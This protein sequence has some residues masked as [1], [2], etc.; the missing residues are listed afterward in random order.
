[1]IILFYIGLYKGEH[2]ATLQYFR[3]IGIG[4]ASSNSLHILVLPKSVLKFVCLVES[5]MI[6]YLHRGPSV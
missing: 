4:T 1:M 6:H 2:D 3:R 5:F